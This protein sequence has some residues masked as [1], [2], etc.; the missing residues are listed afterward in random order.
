MEM[1][2]SEI[3]LEECDQFCVFLDENDNKYQPCDM[4]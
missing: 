4:V 3:T 2:P 1:S